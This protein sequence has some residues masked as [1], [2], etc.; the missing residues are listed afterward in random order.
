MPLEVRFT[1]WLSRSNSICHPGE[2]PAPV[3][4]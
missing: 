2:E 1:S 4:G 3:W